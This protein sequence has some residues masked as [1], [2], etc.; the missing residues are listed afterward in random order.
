MRSESANSQLG[1]LL[2]K[3]NDLEGKLAAARKVAS[4][5]SR[6]LDDPNL[7]EA[8]PDEDPLLTQAR[9][10][11]T[12]RRNDLKTLEIT[13]GDVHPVVVAAREKLANAT[14]ELRNKVT[15]IRAG[16]TTQHANRDAMEAE[17]VEVQ[18]QIRDAERNARAGRYA[19]T[20]LERLR[21]EVTMRLKA[22]DSLFTKLV[23]MRS[24]MVAGQNRMNVV[25]AAIPPRWPKNGI[26]QACLTSA[27]GTFF[28]LLAWLG[29]EYILS[30]TRRYAVAT[31]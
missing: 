29:I 13:Y 11:V 8:I 3:R 6:L 30:N 2:N 10:Q 4:T 7:L 28:V 23:E 5:L 16:N 21:N 20:D 19:S 22:R 18:R 17:Y 15:S 12:E 31:T 9:K 26:M 25:D 14:Q 1:V 27:V 24:Q